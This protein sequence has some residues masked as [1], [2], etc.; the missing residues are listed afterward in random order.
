M[1]DA[2]RTGSGPTSSDAIAVDFCDAESGLFGHVQVE[3]MPGAGVARATGL[4]FDH[5]DAVAAAAD[6]S[7]LES[8][9]DWSS[10]AAGGVEIGSADG[11]TTARLD[12]PAASFEIALSRL[13][14]AAFDPDSG[15]GLVAGASREVAAG[16]VSGEVRWD[17]R[18]TRI[19]CL[20]SFT[21]TW[22]EIDWSGLAA[23]RS[24]AAV[25]EDDSLLAIWSARQ[26]RAQGHDEE[27]LSAAL[28]DERG[29]APLERVLLSTEYDEGHRHRRANVEILQP[30]P[31]EEEDPRRPLR[32]GGKVV[33]GTS[34]E[35]ADL[36]VDVAFF[37]WSM[38]GTPGL[39][40]YEVVRPA[41]A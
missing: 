24:V 11:A 37:R 9:G 40:R 39:G 28:V 23:M 14:G 12:S 27:G 13:H 26:R 17:R 16:R 3:L 33:C 4:L 10:V 34:L 35:V 32:A 1:S 7:A 15:A 6:E 41:S 20:G 30:A 38:E 8:P 25:F 2:V 19:E 22:G 31:D 5:A 36:R 18:T 29:E 21:R